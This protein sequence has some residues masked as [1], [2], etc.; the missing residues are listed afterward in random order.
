MVKLNHILV[1]IMSALVLTVVSTSC[2]SQQQK[3]QD[4]AQD[5]DGL[6]ERLLGRTVSDSDDEATA[7]DDDGDSQPKFD[8]DYINSATGDKWGFA[9]A[10]GDGS[11]ETF[12][13][14]HFRGEGMQGYDIYQMKSLGGS[15]YRLVEMPDE[16]TGI[17]VYV[18][19]GG[20]SIRVTRQTAIR[21]GYGTEAAGSYVFKTAA[22]TDGAASIIDPSYAPERYA[23]KVGDH[24]GKFETLQSG[25][26]AYSFPSGEYARS[27]WVKDGSKLYYVDVSGCKMKDNYAHDGFY[28]GSDGSWDKSVR[29]IDGSNV[30]PQ[31]GAVYVDDGGKSWVFQLTTDSDGTIHGKAHLAYPKGIDFEADYS[32]KSFGSSAYSLFNVKDEFECW[33][34]VVL[35]GGRTLRVSGAGVTEVYHKK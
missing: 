22:S 33:H 5:E 35:D 6:L 24:G 7:T 12:A 32:V 25:E 8:V 27:Q 9:M 19:P 23:I 28:V 17:E 15:R 13:V 4:T 29:C 11:G 26:E 20:E 2:G 30:L 21:T 10:G 31:N 18:L 34:A 1:S 3:S 16:D 14:A